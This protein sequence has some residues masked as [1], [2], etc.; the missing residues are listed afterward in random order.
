MPPHRPAGHVLPPGAPAGLQPLRW[1]HPTPLY[2]VAST[3]SKDG[4]GLRCPRRSCCDRRIT[5]TRRGSVMPDRG[6]GVPSPRRLGGTAQLLDRDRQRG[7]DAAWRGLAR[8][9]RTLAFCG[10]VLFAA[11]VAPRI[12]RPDRRGAA[13]FHLAALGS[14]RGLA[15]LILYFSD[16]AAPDLGTRTRWRAM[17]RGVWC[18]A[19]ALIAA[20]DPLALGRSRVDRRRSQASGGSGRL[21]IGAS[22]TLLA[23]G[24]PLVSR[25]DCWSE[26]LRGRLVLAA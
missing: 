25:R 5:G 10:A 14:P 26:R 23:P 24:G 20:L 8:S 3:P 2:E 11:K 18:Y 12:D 19:V 15:A 22:R 6:R 7:R 4:Q 13:G 17:F 16:S 1:L 9:Q 21:S